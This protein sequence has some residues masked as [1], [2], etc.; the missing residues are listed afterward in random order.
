MEK[1]NTNWANI[2][3]DGNRPI[4]SERNL[5]GVG[6]EWEGGRVKVRDSV[7]I[8]LFSDLRRLLANAGGDGPPHGR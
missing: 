7:P 1:R 3:L 4:P 8:E 2:G 5:S 6:A